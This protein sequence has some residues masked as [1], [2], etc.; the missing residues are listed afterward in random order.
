[1]G[2]YT[3]QVLLA[4]SDEDEDAENE[5]ALTRPALSVTLDVNA[6]AHANARSYYGQT[7]AAAAKT[8]KT[9]E[10]AEHAVHAAEKKAQAKV[11]AMS[12]THSIRAI[13]RNYWWEKFFW[14]VSS[15]NYIVVGGRD[16]Q[17]NEQ[18]VRTHLSP[19][20]VYVHADV[21]GASSYLPYISRRSPVDLP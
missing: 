19:G 17:Q 3:A 12:T 2:R 1:M 4:P 16:A 14:F 18:L 13:R 7:K 20:D 5:E 21:E 10:A 9:L 15:E 11:L 6:S 8:T